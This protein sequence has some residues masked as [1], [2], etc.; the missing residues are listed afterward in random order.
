LLEGK[1][2]KPS[3]ARVKILEYLIRYA[4]HPT[5]E[6]I[7]NQLISEIPTLSKTTVYNS[8]DLFINK[9]LVRMINLGVKESRYDADVSNHGHFKCNHCEQV[10]DFWFE[11][12][13]EAKGLEGFQIS[14]KN[15][16]YRGMCPQC[17]TG[18]GF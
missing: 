5:V 14:D 3:V 2:I 1:N 13:Q 18:K 9:G 11:K 12:E 15:I 16:Y 6:E 8:L 7:Y 17:L 10:Y 4:A